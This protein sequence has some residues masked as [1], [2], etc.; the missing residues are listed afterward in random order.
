MKN[1]NKIIF[2]IMT[3]ILFTNIILNNAQAFYFIDKCINA[4]HM[5][6]TLKVINEVDNSTIYSLKEP[7]M[8]CEYGCNSNTQ[9]CNPIPQY[10][11]YNRGL[12][13][14]FLVM[15]IYL[16]WVIVK[17]RPKNNEGVMVNV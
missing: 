7:D 5:V 10:T 8:F 1:N 6:T 12:A 9:I 14:V 16:A 15:V 3:F 2:G 11:L 4:T 17:T 13:V